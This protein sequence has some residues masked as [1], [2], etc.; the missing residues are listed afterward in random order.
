MAIQYPHRRTRFWSFMMRHRLAVRDLSIIAV[1]ALV[2][3]YFV[4]AVDVFANEDSV[5]QR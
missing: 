4:S 1:G 3:L 5:A 2:A